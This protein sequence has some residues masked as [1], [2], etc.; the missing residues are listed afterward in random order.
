[1]EPD[2][3]DELVEYELTLPRFGEP[4]KFNATCGACGAEW[5]GLRRGD[6]PGATGLT[7]IERN[8]PSGWFDA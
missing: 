7:G 2:D 3:I 1:M 8:A 4:Y 5:H 6:C